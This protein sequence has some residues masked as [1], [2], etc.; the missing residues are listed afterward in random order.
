MPQF[1]LFVFIIY[2]QIHLHGVYLHVCV[3]TWQTRTFTFMPQFVL[4]SLLPSSPSQSLLACACTY[5]WKTNSRMKSGPGLMDINR[6]QIVNRKQGIMKNDWLYIH[7]CA[8][9]LSG[10]LG[11]STALSRSTIS[12]INTTDAARHCSQRRTVVNPL[13]L[14]GLPYY[15]H[16][17]C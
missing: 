11:E 5:T 8:G 9:F 13:H 10:C 4:F 6:K 15:H 12:N 3:Y 2:Y 7:L 14:A 1:V 17:H 16:Q